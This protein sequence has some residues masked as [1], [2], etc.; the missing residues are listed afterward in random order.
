MLKVMPV[1]QDYRQGSIASTTSP[2]YTD[3]GFRK[4]KTFLCI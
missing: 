1:V 3:D 4:P 2:N